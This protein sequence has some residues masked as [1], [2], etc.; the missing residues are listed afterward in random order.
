VGIYKKRKWSRGSQDVFTQLNTLSNFSY[1]IRFFS[2][3]I[4][5]TSND[6]QNSTTR[7][8]LSIYSNSCRGAPCRGGGYIGDE[9][10]PPPA[11]AHLAYVTLAYARKRKFRYPIQWLPCFISSLSR[12][13]KQFIEECKQSIA[14]IE[15]T[16]RQ[17]TPLCI[18]SNSCKGAPCRGGGYIGDGYIPPP[19]MQT[20]PM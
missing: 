19:P 4:Y 17:N 18:S 1:I 7:H 6:K 15:K 12:P 20:P 2:K 8:P 13:Q 16:P 9:Y 3:S 5:D 11:Y 10:I 14:E